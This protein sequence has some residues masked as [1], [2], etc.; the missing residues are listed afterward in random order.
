MELPV[1]DPA[2]RTRD[3]DEHILTYNVWLKAD[4]GQPKAK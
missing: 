3:Q 1:I 2:K 4:S